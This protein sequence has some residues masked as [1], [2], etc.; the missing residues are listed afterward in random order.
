[1][2]ALHEATLGEPTIAASEPDTAGQESGKTQ[3]HSQPLTMQI[4]VRRDLLDVCYID[5]LSIA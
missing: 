4:V 2:S 3:T 1:M 5:L